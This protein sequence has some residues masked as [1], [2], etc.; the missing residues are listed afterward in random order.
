[1][2]KLFALF[3][4]PF[5]ASSILAQNINYNQ[6][7]I[8]Q[9]HYLQEIPYQKIMGVPVVSVTINGKIYKFFFD[10]GASSLVIS[11]NLCKELNLSITGQKIVPGASG[12]QR[13]MK[14]ILFPE[15]HLQEI[16][17]TNIY[18]IVSQEK[19]E[20]FECLGIDGI[21]GGNMLINFIV[22]FDEQRQCI[23]ITD[24]IRNLKLKKVIPQKM[25]FSSAKCVPFITVILK[26]GKEKVKQKVL[27]DSGQGT[28]YEMSMRNYNWRIN[29]IVKKISESEGTF[30]FGI[31]GFFAN[32]EH[33][34]LNIPEII[35]NKIPFN[36]VVITTTHG[37]N[38]RIG[39]KLL[40][41][42]KTTLDYKKKRFYFEPF[43]NINTSEL[44]KLPW[45]INTTMQNDKIVVGIIWDKTLEFQINLGDE[46]LSINGMDIRSM[47]F[48]ELFQL[49][50]SPDVY[51][52][53]AELKDIK[54][55][56]PKKVAIKRLQFIK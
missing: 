24:N 46:I 32:Q 44:S 45:A 12:E 35:V 25:E 49:E 37:E 55:G 40:Q 3:L 4:L 43:D 6:G 7:T 19:Y 42:G 51:E 50:V 11:D 22:H 31:H 20:L 33:L 48:C 17:F 10:T 26:K 2:K 39:A 16:T 41:Y 28:F 9:K 8:K 27:F 36:D 21:I 5:Y 47:N 52:F 53:I 56:E 30:G 29:N 14:K 23:I 15:L 1:M 13:K 38:S 54:T 34:L 18:G